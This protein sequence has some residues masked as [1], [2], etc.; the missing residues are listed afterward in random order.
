MLL[1]VI[2]RT[3]LQ[4]RRPGKEGSKPDSAKGGFCSIIPQVLDEDRA[5]YAQRLIPIS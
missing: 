4:N 1:P 5:G 2:A 3:I